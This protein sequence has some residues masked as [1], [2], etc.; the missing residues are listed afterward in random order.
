MKKWIGIALIV[1]G[2]AGF[3]IGEVSFTTTEQ[4]A[5]VG[6]IQVETENER[7]IPIAPIACGVAILVGIGLVV[8]DMR[9]QKS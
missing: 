9:E 5:D 2:L 4:V 1:L 7:S 8:V 3:A 6:P